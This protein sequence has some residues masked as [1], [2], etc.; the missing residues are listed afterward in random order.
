M[1]TPPLWVAILSAWRRSVLLCCKLMD[2]FSMHLEFSIH[3]LWP[4][5]EVLPQ[6]LYVMSLCKLAIGVYRVSWLMCVWRQLASTAYNRLTTND[7][8]WHRLTL[9][10]YYQL[11]QSVLKIRF[12]ASKKGG[13][14]GGGQVSARDAMHMAAA[15]ASCR[16]TELA[17]PFLTLLA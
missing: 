7:A 14:G 15:L 1:K 12:C 9:A 2:L 8:I 11:A 5:A 3:S 10:A 6:P 13:I 16:K 17:G 4:A